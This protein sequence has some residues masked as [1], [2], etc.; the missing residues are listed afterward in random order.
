MILNFIS[1]SQIKIFQDNQKNFFLNFLFL[2]YTYVWI[3]KVQSNNYKL[4]KTQDIISKSL[5]KKKSEL[6]KYDLWPIFVAKEFHF[7]ELGTRHMNKWK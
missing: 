3:W 2:I 1:W 6:L 7:R 5:Q 4:M